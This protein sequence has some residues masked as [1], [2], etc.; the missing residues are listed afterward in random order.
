MYLNNKYT[1]WYYLIITYAQQNVNREGYSEKHHIIP[2]SL[3]GS[4]DPSNIVKLSA[5]EHY[6]CHLLLIRMTEGTS[7]NKMRY[8]AWMMVKNNPH[9]SRIRLT[10]KRFQT[11]KEQMIKANKERPGPNLGI[12]MPAETRQKLSIALK[13]RKQP[14]RTPE[15]NAKLGRYV[16]TDEHKIAISQSRKSQIGLQKRSQETKLKMSAW[17]KGIPKPTLTC[18]HCNKTI[19]DLNYRRWHGNNCKHK[20]I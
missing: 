4:N 15:H 11:L 1:T 19:S 14:S 17:Q 6:I 10:S 2:K 16:R 18:E 8:A 5:R 13:G 3:G 7:K 9:Q 20:N 12:I